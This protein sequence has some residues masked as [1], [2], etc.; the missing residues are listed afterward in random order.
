MT[1]CSTDLTLFP[2]CTKPV[3]IRADGGA[4]LRPGNVPGGHRAMALIKAVVRRLRA[5][6]PE[7]V[8]E[9]RADSALALPEVYDGC[10][11]LSMPYTLSL[12]KNERLTEL[13]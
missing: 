8:I 4:L 6:F 5:A 13:A 11:K 2:L 12:P 10:E 3:V 7:C 1:E 9:L